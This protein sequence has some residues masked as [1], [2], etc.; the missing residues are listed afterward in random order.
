MRV[1]HRIDRAEEVKTQ[2]AMIN[3][4]GNE[5]RVPE[6]NLGHPLLVRII[7]RLL[8]AASCLCLRIG[9]VWQRAILSKPYGCERHRPLLWLKTA[10]QRA[11]AQL[12]TLEPLCVP[13]T[14]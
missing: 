6:E 3:W 13:V 10:R 8:C 5:H 11:M 7:S 4:P 9:P 1:L 12:S 2:E 14:H